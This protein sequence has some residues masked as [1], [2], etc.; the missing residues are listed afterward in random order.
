MVSGAAS[1]HSHLNH[2]GHP[3]SQ[4]PP[5]YP[6][7]E[8]TSNCS[9]LAATGI[10]TR[11]GG[12]SQVDR[13]VSNIVPGVQEGFQGMTVQHL[14]EAHLRKIQQELALHKEEFRLVQQQL[15]QQLLVPTQGGGL[16]WGPRPSC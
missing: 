8:G 15:R 1:A 16:A 12:L 10:D 6:I 13:G 9:S 5:G 14:L 7:L 11:G 3:Y 4:P 2:L